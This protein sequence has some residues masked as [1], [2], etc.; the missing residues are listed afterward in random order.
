M[1]DD[2]IPYV[3]NVDHISLLDA[4]DRLVGRQFTCAMI[5]NDASP[6]WSAWETPRYTTRT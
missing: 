2:R 6:D 5:V 3:N 4:V 1:S